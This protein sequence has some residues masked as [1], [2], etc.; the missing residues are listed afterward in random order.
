MKKLLSVVLA[1]LMLLPVFANGVL[2]S[3]YSE[4]AVQHVCETTES[5][6]AADENVISCDELGEKLYSD[7]NN[8]NISNNWDYVEQNGGIY[9]TYCRLSD[10]E[11]TIPD[12][13]DGKPVVGIDYLGWR[14]GVKTLNVPDSVIYI[15]NNAIPLSD[16]QTLNLGAN[17]STLSIDMIT[18]CSNLSVINIPE[19]NPNF[20]VVDGIVYNK[21]GDTL[22]VYPLGKGSVY[23]IP[24]N[25]TNID[26]MLNNP[27]Y[28]GISF[29]FSENSKIF[30][31]I[32]GV[33]YTYDMQTVI[34]CDPE[35]TGEYTM[36]DSVTSI[37]SMAFYNTKLSKVNVSKNV[38]EITYYSFAD[39]ANLETINMP[40]NVTTID[41]YAFYCSNLKNLT[42]LPK[43]LVNLND[44]A[45]ASTQLQSITI[46]DSV[47]QMGSYAFSYSSLKTL[48]LGS[49]LTSIPYFAFENTKLT[50]VTIPKNIT[51]INSCAFSN[52]LI[53]TVVFEGEGVL[54]GSSA[55]SGCP[56]DNLTLNDNIS[57]IDAWAF[58]HTGMK[59]IKIPDSVTTITYYSFAYS[60]DLADID[61]PENLTRVCGHA[62][63][64]T[65]WYNAQKAGVVYLENVLYYYKG[66]MPKNTEIDVKDGTT[67][68]ADYAFE[69]GYNPWAGVTT[70]DVSEF[71]SIYIPDSV[72]HIGR[73]AFYGCENLTI[74]GSENSVA[75]SY[76]QSN[77]IPFLVMKKSGDVSV[78][79]APG[80]IDT[81][82]NFV[83]TEIDKD[84]IIEKLPQDMEYTNVA[85]FDTGF[86]LDGE[87]IAPDTSVS[88][89]I[90]VP[91]G[92][93]GKYCTV[94][95]VAEDGVLTAIDSTFKNGKLIFD[96][97]NLGQYVVVE[98]K[99][100]YVSGD[101]ND[102]ASIN[103]KD[104]GLL[105]Q[106][107]NNWKVDINADAADVNRD[108]SVNNKDY[109]LLMQY[110]NNWKV[111]LL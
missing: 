53:S 92:L 62:F 90:N 55:F 100:P 24:D 42:T 17:I 74:Y 97:D 107:L 11:L 16:L 102:D 85:A 87:A 50:E 66:A 86:E 110:L 31:K 78:A 105:M 6:V 93:I 14:Y 48:T 7:S 8:S 91:A 96:T 37:K 41:E 98:N 32:D 54:I 99:P 27:N 68:I 51:S 30:K 22:I 44:Y 81:N 89:R 59:S 34:G 9:I 108:G 49:G 4:P 72:K 23:N 95:S 46:P 45:F 73:D 13:I 25:V 71:E 79:F 43:N 76:A 83:A 40:D 47:T 80:V 26:V 33:S 3:A 84:S 82:I 64:G 29:T 75:Q 67:V 52:S 101:I 60:K 20:K 35:K 18:Y 94:Y 104:L 57:Y 109:G 39:C 69:K 36:P 88:V 28:S 61:V 65:A 63:D 106:H 111:E 1:I 103:N 70:R 58:S 38:T 19:S 10:E 77:K 21:T 2:A 12:T 5:S 15:S 56:L